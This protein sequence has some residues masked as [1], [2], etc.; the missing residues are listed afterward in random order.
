VFAEPNLGVTSPTLPA[1]PVA[2]PLSSAPAN[3]PAAH[4]PATIAKPV[5]LAAA[6]RKVTKAQKKKIRKHCAPLKTR[7]KRASCVKMHTRQVQRGKKLNL[8]KKHKH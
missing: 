4:H 8:R 3:H 1:A 6:K 2:V 5:K 7:K